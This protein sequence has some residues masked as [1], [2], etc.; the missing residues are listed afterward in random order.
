MLLSLTDAFKQYGDNVIFSGLSLTLNYGDKIGLVGINGSGKSTL[1]KVM[2][3]EVELDGGTITRKKG[4]KIGYVEQMQSVNRDL[5]VYSFVYNGNDYIVNLEKKIENAEK[6]EVSDPR[7]LTSLFEEYEKADGYKYKAKVDDVLKGIGISDLRDRKVNTLSGGELRRVYLARVLVSDAELLLFDE[8]TNHLDLFAVNWFKNYLAETKKAFVLVSHDEFLLN[9]TVRKIV[10]I[11]SGKAF[12]FNG[13]YSFYKEKRRELALQAEREYKNKVEEIEREMEFVR[14]NIAGQKTKQ[15]KSRLKKIEKIELGEKMLFKD[16]AIKLKFRE[17]DKKSKYIAQCENLSFG[18]DKPIV[19]NVNLLIQRGE[20][21]GIVGR[22]GSGKTTFLKTLVGKLKPLS[23]NAKIYPGIKVGYFDQNIEFEDE[24]ETVINTLWNADP[25][26]KRDEVLNYLAYF[27]FRKGMV[28]SKVK[29]LSGGERSRLKL[30][31]LMLGEYDLLI[32]DEPTN[33][34]DI[35]LTEAITEAVKNFKGSVLTVS[36]HRYFLDSTVNKVIELKN[37][38]FTLFHGGISYY[39]DKVKEFD[40]KKLEEKGK[41]K[42]NPKIK[43]K[44]KKKEAVSKNERLRAKWRLEEVEKEIEKL[45]D[46]K[47]E[48]EL[49]LADKEVVN[50]YLKIKSLS[51]EL[52][53]IDERLDSLLNEWQRLSEICMS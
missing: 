32:L 12:F 5:S 22:N 9:K 7:L 2:A 37:G 10:E 53:S 38:N 21:Y 27:Y 49:M 44:P 6:G 46:R 50:D 30:A 39:F 17:T 18:Y 3:G 47:K 28:E 26:L 36:H 43:E 4:L 1:I 24:E 25:S 16:I 15:A 19:N 35:L 13:D 34:L 42:D 40:E 20:K 8:P 31:C 29:F 41:K 48:I 11:N 45:E 52:S 23:G 14:R 51:D 33:H